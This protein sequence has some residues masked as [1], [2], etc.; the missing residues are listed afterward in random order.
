MG[1]RVGCGI[2]V[3]EKE[4][5]MMRV[6]METILLGTSTLDYWAFGFSLSFAILKNTTFWKLDL[7]PSSIEMVGGTYSVGFVG[8]L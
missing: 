8:K 6:C 5:H 1:S 7:L 2:L 3:P 4:I